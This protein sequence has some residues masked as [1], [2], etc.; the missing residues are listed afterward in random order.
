MCAGLIVFSV[1]LDAS[2]GGGV[3]DAETLQVRKRGFGPLVNLK[4]S[5]YQ[6]RLG[7]NI[8]KALKKDGRFLQTRSRLYCA[9]TR[10]HMMAV[11]AV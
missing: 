6:D 11:R 2:M 3:P 7:T 8:R 4:G 10:A 9:L 5:F 1:G